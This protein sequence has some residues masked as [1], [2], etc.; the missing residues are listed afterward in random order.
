MAVRRSL[1]RPL[2]AAFF[3]RPTL[4]VARELLGARL[5]H[6][7]PEGRRSGVIVEVEAYVGESDPGCHA[8]PGPTQ[9]NQPLYGPPGIAYVYLNYGI[10]ALLN[11]VTEADGQPAAILLRG[12]VPEEGLAEMRRRRTRGRGATPPDPQLC[13]GPGNLARAFGVTLAHNETPLTEGALTI[14]AGEPVAADV[15]WTRRIGLSR[16]DDR[17]W[18]CIVAGASGVS[19]TRRWNLD[20]RLRPHPARARADRR[21]R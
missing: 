4:V 16:G 11:V 8:W 19:G 14:Q 6:E 20:A 13:R 15:R 5:V 7:T 9:R 18:R 3:A 2:P 21:I 12:I 17:Y 1:D 10:H